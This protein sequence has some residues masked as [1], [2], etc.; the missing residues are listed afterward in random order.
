MKYL[1]TILT[2][3][4]LIESINSQTVGLV[5]SGGGAK[6]LAHIGVIKALEENEIPIDYIAG[7]SMG[8]IVS[9]LYAIGYSPEEMITLFK[10]KD[11]YYWSTGQLNEA[12]KYFFNEPKDDASLLDFEVNVDS[13]FLKPVLPSNIIPTYQ[14]DLAFVK[15]FAAANALCKSNFDSLFIPFRCVASDIQNKK[16]VVFKNGDLGEAIRSSM[17]IP[18]Y[19]KPL[20]INGTLLFDGG[21]YNNFPWKELNKDFKPN[22]IIGSKVANNTK[23]P[24]ED[25]ILL[26]LENMIVG[27]TDYSIPDSLGVLIETNL[28]D[29]GILDFDKID[30]IVNI[31]YQETVK[32]I[33]KIKKRVSRRKTLEDLSR[34]RIQF[35]NQIPEVIFKKLYING[36][37]DKQKQY[38]L[39]SFKRK[40]EIFTVPQAEKIYYKLVSEDFIKRIYPTTKFNYS[41]NSFDLFLNTSIKKNLNISLGGN[42]SSSSIN[43]GFVS[44]SYSY[45]GKTTNQFY[46]NIYFGRLYSSIDLSYKKKIPFKLPLSITSSIILNR[47]DYYR[48]SNDL[49]FEDIKPSY[50]IKNEGFGNIEFCFPISTSTLVKNSYSFGGLDDQYYQNSNFLHTDTPDKTRFNFFNGEFS[51]VKRTLNKKQY[52]YKGR[53]Q[54]IKVNYISGSEEHIPGST[55]SDSIITKYNH[56][57]Y[58][59]KLFSESYHKI[60]SDYIWVGLLAELNYSNKPFFSNY[61]S[62]ILTTPGFSPSP[63]SRTLFINNLHSEKYIALGIIPNIKLYKEIFIRAEG[64][65]YKPI[66]EIEHDLNNKAIYDKKFQFNKLFGSISLVVHTP[67]G[68]LSLSVNY[69]PKEVKEYYVIFNYGLIL[70]NKKA[71]E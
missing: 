26:Q 20:V 67:I 56:T 15:I 12:N 8:A 1:F 18:I 2:L 47:T 43:Q 64:Y 7:T 70:F 49:F 48:S 29:I 33:E 46:A 5:L 37:N 25:D 38:I 31:G 28:K 19:F 55:S 61:T 13:S 4:L 23:P 71:L 40:S 44:T 41:S 24:E 45:F 30:Y 21:I 53:N 11:F 60:F 39:K 66:Y 3:L 54:F 52:A 35:K 51:I 50:L 27:Q 65:W 9:G 59:I 42:L 69:Y 14:M 32:N 10:S 22:F 16:Q 36:L 34:K 57:W 63:H 58:N 6:G 17:T 62:T 68:P